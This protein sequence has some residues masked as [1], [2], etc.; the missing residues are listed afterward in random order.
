[1]G[2]EVTKEGADWEVIEAGGYVGLFVVNPG[3]A[4]D[5]CVNVC[6]LLKLCVFL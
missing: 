1:M 3:N 2:T 5:I 6:L 4:F